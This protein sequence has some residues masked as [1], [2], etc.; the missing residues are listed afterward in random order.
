MLLNC[1]VLLKKKKKKVIIIS[2]RTDGTRKTLQ[3]TFNLTIYIGN[4][5]VNNGCAV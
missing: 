3:R 5:T 4:F 2:N 1:T